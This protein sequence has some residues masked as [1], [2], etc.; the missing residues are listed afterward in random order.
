MTYAGLSQLQL[1]ALSEIGNIGAG[2]AAT[3]LSQLLNK[4]IDMKMP[5]VEIVKFD[6]MMELIGGPDE[7]IVALLFQVSDDLPCHVY[8]ILTVEE[9]E[10]LVQS[11]TGLEEFS[12]LQDM[13]TNEFAV[14]ALKEIGNIVIGSYLSALSDFTK[15]NLQPSIPHLAV[16]MA[17]AILTVGLLEI[18]QVS[19]HVITINTSIK[20]NSVEN[21]EG[22]FFLL[23]EPESLHMLFEA[24]GIDYD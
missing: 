9:A 21:I 17:A 6:H 1:D 11:I 8:F 10:A 16:D 14:S 23:P 7:I 18:S 12:L 5:Q 24:L 2:N 22:Q 3:S 4:K 15:L 13:G 20:S 19:D